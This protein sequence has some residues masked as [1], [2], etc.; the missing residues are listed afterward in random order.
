MLRASAKSV[1]C[2][3]ASGLE[4]TGHHLL[5]QCVDVA[6]EAAGVAG[7]GLLR[8]AEPGALA[9]VR[10]IGAWALDRLPVRDLVVVHVEEVEEGAD[11]W[12]GR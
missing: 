8:E 9:Q 1:F 4:I 10:V 11:L 3:L 6:L 12:L 2:V 7:P 5:D